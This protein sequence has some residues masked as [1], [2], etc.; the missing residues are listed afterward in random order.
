[1]DEE[2]LKLG[3]GTIV[4]SCASLASWMVFQTSLSVL[5]M[6][7]PNSK[8]C[9]THKAIERQRDCLAEGG[10][11]WTYERELNMGI[12]EDKNSLGGRIVTTRF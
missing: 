10:L 7:E 8:I 6:L 9:L 1:L 4:A 11:V 5:W 2:P 12:L 3:R